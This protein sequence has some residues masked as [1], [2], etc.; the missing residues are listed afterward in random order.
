MFL[1]RS[2]CPVWSLLQT[3]KKLP[4]VS[5]IPPRSRLSAVESK[6]KYQH[7]P[8]DLQAK[9]DKSHGSVNIREQPTAANG[10]KLVLHLEDSAAGPSE[11]E[12]LITWQLLP[13]HFTAFFALLH[14]YTRGRTCQRSLASPAPTKFD[15]HQRDNRCRYDSPHHPSDGFW[16]LPSRLSASFCPG[17]FA[18]LPCPDIPALRVLWRA[19]SRSPHQPVLGMVRHGISRHALSPFHRTALTRVRHPQPATTSGSLAGTASRLPS[20]HWLFCPACRNS[21]R[22]PADLFSHALISMTEARDD[23][24]RAQFNGL[25]ELILYF[26]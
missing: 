14:S 2:F 19:P 3:P 15:D 22:D 20:E 16:C 13:A 7:E 4:E 8:P 1:A 11:F 26:S 10:Q 6:S 12:L 21:L 24:L 18:L 23:E 17:G 9:L 5:G 25:E